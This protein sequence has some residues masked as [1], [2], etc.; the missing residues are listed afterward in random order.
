[1]A[2]KDAVLNLHKI[3]KEKIEIQNRIPLDSIDGKLDDSSD[4]GI[5]SLVYTP[6][7][8]HVAKEIADNKELAYNYPSKWN[9]V[10]IVCDGSRVLGLG[11]IG[12]EGA[13]PVMEG[14]SAL[15]IKGH[16]WFSVMH[17]Y[18]R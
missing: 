15:F 14:K 1:M 9:S 13:I 5:L 16:Q 11:N 17:R 6:G 7:V 3:L 8:A 2:S 4:D 18:P 10:A 12:P